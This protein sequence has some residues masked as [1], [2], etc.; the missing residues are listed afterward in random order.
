MRYG[1]QC[2]KHADALSPLESSRA[3]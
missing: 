3:G 2:L 1:G